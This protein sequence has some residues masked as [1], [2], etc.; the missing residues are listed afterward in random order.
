[1]A[2]TYNGLTGHAALKARDAAIDPPI[3]DPEQALA[4]VK[5]DTVPAPSAVPIVDVT[6]YLRN[7]V[8]QDGS[9]AW[10]AVLGAA[11]TSPAAKAAVEY[12]SDQRVQVI[13]LN[14]PV[15]RGLLASLVASNVITQAEAD[16]VRALIPPDQP[17]WD[18]E[19]SVE[20]LL[21]ARSL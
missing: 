15:V 14:T 9:T 7:R 10:L 1:M 13:D 16:G 8:R 21:Y 18:P 19:P 3:Q 6:H 17:A 5:A 12:N 2:W 11:E 20:D 4:V